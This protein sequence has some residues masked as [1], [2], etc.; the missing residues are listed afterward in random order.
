MYACNTSKMESHNLIITIIENYIL[1]NYESK[2]MWYYTT[3][4]GNSV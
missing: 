1:F 4:D 2:S 3:C